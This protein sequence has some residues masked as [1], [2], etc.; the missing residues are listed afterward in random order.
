METLGTKADQ[1]RGPDVC[2]Q[3]TSQGR[4]AGSG[5]AATA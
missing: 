4:L 1:S 3:V 2:Q 5:N